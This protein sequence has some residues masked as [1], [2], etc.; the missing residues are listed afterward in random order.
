MKLTD[1]QPQLYRYEKVVRDI[2]VVVGD[3]ATWKSGDPTQVETRTCYDSVPVPTI[4]EAQ[5]IW[6]LC[7]KC[8]NSSGHMIECTIAGRGV[9]D[10][11][12]SHNK[13]GQPVRWSISGTDFSN[14]SLQPSVQ[15]QGGCDWHGFVT[16]GEAQ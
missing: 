3:P 14:L 16:N 12:G 1:L 7:P 8:V 15:I 10:A 11:C 5:S 13:A 2:E 9:E 6:F 4:G